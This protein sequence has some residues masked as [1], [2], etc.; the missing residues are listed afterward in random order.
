MHALRTEVVQG[1]GGVL[2]QVLLK[3]HDRGDLARRRKLVVGDH[4]VRVD[5]C[6]DAGAATGEATHLL[7]QVRVGGHG[8]VDDELGCAQDPGLGV[9]APR[10]PLAGRGEGDG[11]LGALLRTGQRFFVQETPD[12]LSRR[13][14]AVA[15]RSRQRATHHG[16]LA[17]DDVNLAH[18]DATRRQRA[19]LIQAQAVDAGQHLDRGQLLDEDAPAGQRRRSDREVHGGQQHQALRN[20]AD[21]RRDGE[22]QGETPVSPG[23]AGDT[24]LRVERQRHDREQHDRD[25]LQ[26]AVDRHLN[27]RDRARVGARL[28]GQALR[29][30][31]LAH[32]R[33]DH[34]ARP[35]HDTRAGQELVADLLL[36]WARLARQ[37]RLVDFQARGRQHRAVHAH[38]I[39]QGQLDDIVDHDVARRNHRHRPVAQDGRLR[40]IDNR[41]GVQRALGAQLRDDADHRVDDHNAAE[42][43]VAQ[44]TEQQDNDRRSDNDRIEERHHVLADDRCHG[45]RR[46]ILDAVDRAA[47]HPFKD[48]VGTQAALV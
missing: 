11:P 32:R 17:R 15:R 22:H 28:L 29:V 42:N 39:T 13:V 14:R 1:L 40:R 31:A 3:N 26:D 12:R 20:H 9:G 21:H 35:G 27:L 48:L 5:E 37:Q 33:G 47:R 2:S 19:R 34:A 44:V 8:L 43:T 30:H 45:P 10:A 36:D 25:D 38:L 46:A 6:D 18:A 23:A 41:Q 16:L 4:R 7:Q 24:V